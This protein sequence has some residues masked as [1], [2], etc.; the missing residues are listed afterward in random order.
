MTTFHIGTVEGNKLCKI[1]VNRILIYYIVPLATF[2]KL[3]IDN[4][5]QE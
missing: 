2:A 4:H 5:K 1:H 3:E